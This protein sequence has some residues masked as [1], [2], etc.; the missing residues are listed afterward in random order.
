M[1]NQIGRLRLTG[2]L[3]GGLIAGE[4]DCGFPAVIPAEKWG[5]VYGCALHHEAAQAAHLHE[6]E[7]ARRDAAAEQKERI[8]REQSRNLYFAPHFEEL[9]RASRL[10]F[11]KLADQLSFDVNQVASMLGMSIE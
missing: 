7:I 9:S 11:R 10:L 3:A 6:R 4:C 2:E 8:K 5:S 1:K